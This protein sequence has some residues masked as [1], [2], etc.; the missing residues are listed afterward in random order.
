VTSW[1]RVT[2]GIARLVV[3]RTSIIGDSTSNNSFSCNLSFN[4]KKV[5][6]KYHVPQQLPLAPHFPIL[7]LV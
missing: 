7:I 4:K 2:G 1:N 6:D 5:N 3:L